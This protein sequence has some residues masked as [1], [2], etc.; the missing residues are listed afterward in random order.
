VE[1]TSSRAGLPP[2]GHQRLFTA[3]ADHPISKSIAERKLGCPHLSNDSAV[4]D[5]DHWAEL[6]PMTNAKGYAVIPRACF[7]AIYQ[8]HTQS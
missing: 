8:Q 5:N 7:T 1:R 3:H 6:A 4:D 2:A